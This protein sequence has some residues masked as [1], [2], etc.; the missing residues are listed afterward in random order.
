M[1]QLKK[2]TFISIDIETKNLSEDDLEMEQGLVKAAT[3]IKD[4]AKIKANVEKKRTALVSRGALTN[5]C[6][7][8]SIGIHANGETPLVLHTF[9]FSSDIEGIEHEYFSSEQEMLKGFNMFMDDVCT[10]ETVLV[11]AGRDF[12]F[13]KL[14]LRSVMNNVPMANAMRP[15]AENTIYDVLFMATKYFM[16]GNKFSISLDELC[17]RLGI[18]SGGKAISGKEVPGMIERGEFEEVILYNA[19]DA[20]KNSECYIKM[21]L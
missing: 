14:R 1:L 16:I 17:L 8:G 5:S 19:M 3:N 2:K 18:N 15:G 21:T 20:V 9:D 4:P 10:D 11:V 6:E 12:D 13:P 7:I